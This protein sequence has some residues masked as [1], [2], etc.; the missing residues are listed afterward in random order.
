MG[1]LH[2]LNAIWNGDKIG[3]VIDWE[4]TG[5]KPDIYDAA[6]LVGC[7]G[8]ED[9]NGLGM[10][11]VMSFINRVKANKLYSDQGW[12]LFPEYMLALRFAWLS[13]WLRKKDMEM[14][15]MEQAYM[16]LL[17]DNMDVLRVG[18]EM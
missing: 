7:A 15:E 18:W 4:F 10:P 8:I 13:E 12:Q 6:N 14:I 17:M 11:M 1:D 2:P 5:I 3:A 16:R 9:P